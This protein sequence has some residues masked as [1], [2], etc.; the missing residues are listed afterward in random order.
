MRTNRRH[1]NITCRR[2]SRHS[3][4]NPSLGDASS[5]PTDRICDGVASSRMNL[6]FAVIHSV[7][8]TLEVRCCLVLDLVR[9]RVDL[10]AVQTKIQ[11]YTIHTSCC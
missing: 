10:E 11:E 5:R 7:T 8:R 1:G 3:L 6:V 4:E 2:I 9:Q